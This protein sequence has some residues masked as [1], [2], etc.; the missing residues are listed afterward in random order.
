MRVIKLDRCLRLGDASM[1]TL[2]SMTSLGTL[3]LVSCARI[4]NP[5][6]ACLAALEGLTGL[7]LEQLG[8]LTDD[9]LAALRPLSNLIALNVGW[10]NSGGG[11]PP[12]ACMPNLK[13][14]HICALAIPETAFEAVCSRSLLTSLHMSNCR[15][16]SS[17]TLDMLSRLCLLKCLDVG[18]CDMVI[19]DTMAALSHIT[20]LEVLALAHTH[21]TDVGVQHLSA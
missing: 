7:N 3:S 17:R 14:L 10:C 13:K 2:G 15:I 20:T 9:G 6:V 4:G 21:V 5:G 12:L 11:G 8:R 18:Q 16:T 1:Q 19:D